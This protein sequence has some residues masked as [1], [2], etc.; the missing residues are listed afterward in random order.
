MFSPTDPSGG[1][2]LQ[3]DIL[4]LHA[5]GCHALSVATG[6]TAQSADRLVSYEPSTTRQVRAQFE[7]VGAAA[8][9]CRAA[10]VGAVGTAALARALGRI[11]AALPKARLVVDPVVAPSGGGHPFMDPRT[12]AAVRRHL[13]AR[14][15]VAT[16][17]GDEARALTKQRDV[18]DAASA[19]LDLGCAHV[20][21]T[22]LRTRGSA[23][24][25]RLY[26]A[27]GIAGEWSFPR[28]RECHGT[29]C[30]LAAAV[31]A[32][33][34]FAPSVAQAVDLA[35][36]FAYDSTLNAYPVEGLGSKR[37]QRRVRTVV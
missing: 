10:K 27:G 37:I 20:L 14:A 12:A 29:G 19:L 18:G 34:V 15:E 25:A 3:A 4:T 31:A 22:S 6:V 8:R 30:T 9:R 5:L 13:L 33:L 35:L 11:A 28:Q 21:V 24:E 36:A 1:A 23:V 32:K 2:G 7:S 26:S 17:N 16:P